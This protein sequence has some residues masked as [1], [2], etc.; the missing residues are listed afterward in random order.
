M[1]QDAFE[2]FGF[3]KRTNYSISHW[4]QSVQ[5]DPLLDHRT[6]PEL[7]ASADIVIIG[8]G[9]SVFRCSCNLSEGLL[10]AEIDVWDNNRQKHR[11]NPARKE[12]GR[13]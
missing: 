2:N 8:S 3:P 9:V 1:G 7:P 13:Y 10:R 4:L 6:T 5:G 11:G 12:S